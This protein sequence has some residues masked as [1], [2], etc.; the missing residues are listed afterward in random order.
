MGRPSGYALCDAGMMYD[1]QFWSSHGMG[2][3]ILGVGHSGIS[4]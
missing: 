2:G 4:R 1:R 3:G